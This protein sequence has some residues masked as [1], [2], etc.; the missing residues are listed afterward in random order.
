MTGPFRFEDFAQE[1]PEISPMLALS[2]EVPLRRHG[3]TLR[4]PALKTVGA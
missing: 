3:E 2:A 4:K 1:K